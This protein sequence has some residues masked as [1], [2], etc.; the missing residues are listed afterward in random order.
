MSKWGLC[1]NTMKTNIV[2]FRRRG[3][4]RLDKRWTYN[5]EYLKIVNDFNYLG[6]VFYYT[7]LFILNQEVLTGKGLTS[8]NM[9]LSKVRTFNL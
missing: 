7:G 8:L 9:L 1:I 6:V 5:G 3:P 2:V 4:V